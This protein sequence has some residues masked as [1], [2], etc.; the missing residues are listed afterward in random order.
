LI[1]FIVQQKI[2]VIEDASSVDIFL[3]VP[4]IVSENSPTRYLC[5]IISKYLLFVTSPVCA[6]AGVATTIKAA[7]KDIPNNIFLMYIINVASQR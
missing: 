7:T 3:T 5:S 1:G 4:V 2:N 6:Y